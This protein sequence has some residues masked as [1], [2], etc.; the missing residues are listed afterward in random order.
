MSQAGAVQEGPP[1]DCYFPQKR[2]ERAGIETDTS[3]PN[4]TDFLPQ[5]FQVVTAAER[6]LDFDGN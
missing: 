5:L 2:K 3:S 1:V 6:L 4:V